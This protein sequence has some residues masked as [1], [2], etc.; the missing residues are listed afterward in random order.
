MEVPNRNWGDFVIFTK[1]DI[2]IER[3]NYFLIRKCLWYFE[4]QILL[5]LTPNE[6]YSEDERNWLRSLSSD[7]SDASAAKKT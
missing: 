4:I 1:C 3:I 7:I 2:I 6:T 5:H